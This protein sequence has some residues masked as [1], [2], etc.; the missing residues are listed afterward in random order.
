MPRRPTFLRLLP[1]IAAAGC[2]FG[3]APAHAAP[4]TLTLAT[5]NLEWLMTPATHVALRPTCTREDQPYVPA[6]SIPCDV[7][8]EPTRGAA[9]FSRLRQYV[10]QL[11]ADVIALQEVDGPEAAR[12]VFTDHD[13]CF[14]ARRSVQNNGFAI[15]RGRGIR[16][17]CGPDYAALA[18]GRGHLRA[19]AQLTLF[20]GTPQELHLLGVHL[21]S[22][23]ARQRLDGSLE[24]CELLSRQIAPLRAWVHM[25]ATAGRRFMLL[26][27]FNRRLAVEQG[28][29]RG[30]MWPELNR[31][32]AAGASL[33]AIT[34]GQP[35]IKCS[36]SE[37]H[38]AYIDHIIAGEAAAARWVPTS[39]R[40]VS[41][42]Q[43]DVSR[44]KLSDHCPIA[45]DYRP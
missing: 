34:A 23:C 32:A 18:A 30:G 31:D 2:A 45:V 36:L 7:A 3:Q 20:P 42:E 1:L 5:W 6:R 39:F 15:R 12:Q 4:S 44:L 21:K 41:F 29:A 9:D 26:G 22:G 14:T 24:A 43:R 11:D 38:G 27:D 40:R 13:F 19:G 8:R 25:Q 17:V 16:F 37:P 35:Y 28:K 33:T 10:A